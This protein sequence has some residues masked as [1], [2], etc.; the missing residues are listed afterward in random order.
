MEEEFANKKLLV[1][2]YDSSVQM[3][4]LEELL[5]VYFNEFYIDKPER[6]KISLRYSCIYPYALSAQKRVFVSLEE[7]MVDGMIQ[8]VSDPDL[9]EGLFINNDVNFFLSMCKIDQLRICERIDSNI[10]TARLNKQN[11]QEDYIIVNDYASALLKAN[12]LS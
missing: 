5:T 7:E 3:D 11:L 2:E 8:K 9:E 12:L 4:T 1:M 6:E 10:F